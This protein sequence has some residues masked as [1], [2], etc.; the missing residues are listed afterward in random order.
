MREKRL[1]ETSW[2]VKDLNGRPVLAGALRLEDSY[3]LRSGA[4]QYR[5]I[6]KEKEKKDVL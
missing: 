2:T 4:Y 3:Y 6:V 1:A 5:I